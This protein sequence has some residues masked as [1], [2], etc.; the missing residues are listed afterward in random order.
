MIWPNKE[1]QL[2][3]PKHMFLV[4]EVM[5]VLVALISVHYETQRQ[6]NIMFDR[7]FEF[8]YS[9]GSIWRL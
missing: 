8:S 9:T 5:S 2:S 3:F 7:W 4:C 6:E 1:Q